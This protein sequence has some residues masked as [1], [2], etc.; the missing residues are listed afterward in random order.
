MGLCL[1]LTF[2]PIDLHICF[3]IHIMSDL[4]TLQHNLESGM[5][6]PLALLN[7]GMGYICMCGGQK[8]LGTL[9]CQIL[10]QPGPSSPSDHPAPYTH[11]HTL[12]HTVA[13]ELQMPGFFTTAGDSNPGPTACPPGPLTQPNH[14]PGP[15]I[16]SFAYLRYFMFS[17]TI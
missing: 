1:D 15:S 3:C 12:S 8:T 4:L 17:D 5:V 10:T 9:L 14:L 6:I 13:L 2:R 16:P 11:T 7:V